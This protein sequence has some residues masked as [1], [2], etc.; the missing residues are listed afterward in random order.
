MHH[1]HAVL[2]RPL[3]LA[4]MLGLL[5]LMPASSEAQFV[6]GRVIPP[7]PA[8]EATSPATQVDVSSDGRVVAFV[9]S[10]P[11]WV[12]G[13]GPGNAAIAGDFSAD[14]Y[15]NLSR[16]SA[17]VAF[18]AASFDP[19]LSAA[20]RFAAF[21]T[22]ANNL[23]VGTATSGQ[24]IVRKDRQTGALVLV[25]ANALGAPAAGSAVGQAREPSISG[26]G[27]F[28][29]FRSDA[30]NLVPG[31]GG[32]IDDVFVKDLD[33]GA[34]EVVSRDANGAFT[35]AGVIGLTSHSLSGDGRFVLFQS[36]AGNLVAGVA[37]GSI[38]VY[39]RDR[40][41][42]T[43]ELASRNSNGD[44]ANSQS[45]VG[46]ISPGGRFVSFR[47]FAGNLGPSGVSA[48]YVRD[49]VAA[50]T[51]QVPLPTVDGVAATGCRESDV[52][53]AGTVILACFFPL[54]VAQQV[55]LHVPGTAG[56]PFLVSSDANDSRGNQSSAPSLAI[57]AS[58]LSMAFESL[59][60]NLVPGDGNGTSD[61]FVLFDAQ[62]LSR[63]FR[64]GFED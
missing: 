9:G 35:T 16:T 22:Q 54:P 3:P 21:A 43:T 44:P 15:D 11:E 6:F 7:A 19:V 56:T 61:V 14:G 32:G 58:G 38:Q 8:I 40:L 23:D 18:N 26:D 47:S 50:T 5:A 29:A 31:D 10:G 17:G 25:S 46:A 52:S 30:N 41:L 55:F 36:S 2:V 1:A 51:S 49:R 28:V 48:V 63:I 57:N 42:G 64:D 59:A 20:G 62:A 60:S 4:A 33:T 12:P 39:V 53:D 27:R 34:I 45:D 37:G 13:S 24:H